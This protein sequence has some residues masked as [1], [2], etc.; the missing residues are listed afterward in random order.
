M[1][2]SRCSSHEL[3]PSCAESNLLEPCEA[4]S[5]GDTMMKVIRGVIV[6]LREV[7]GNHLAAMFTCLLLLSLG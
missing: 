4:H 5:G 2:N 3:L 1:M 7:I 6:N